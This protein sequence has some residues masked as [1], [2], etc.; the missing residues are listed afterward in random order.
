MRPTRLRFFL[1]FV[2]V[3]LSSL[4]KLPMNRQLVAQSRKT[5]HVQTRRV[6]AQ[7]VAEGKRLNLIEVT[8][9]PDSHTMQDDQGC[10]TAIYVTD[11]TLRFEAKGHPKGEGT[12]SAG[13]AFSEPA[14]LKSAA[15]RNESTFREARYLRVSICEADQTQP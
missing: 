2:L 9:G 1:P 14:H 6:L 13:S 8:L 4:V 7:P 12:Y 10:Q 3:V 11:G 5:E 15:Y